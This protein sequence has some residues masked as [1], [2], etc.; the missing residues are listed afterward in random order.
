[1]NAIAPM[2]NGV[3]KDEVERNANPVWILFRIVVP[4]TVPIASAVD[5]AVIAFGFF[6]QSNGRIRNTLYIL[7]G[8]LVWIILNR[9]Y[10]LVLHQ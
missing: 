4:A 8:L 1:M 7:R 6:L 2:I 9:V 5:V 3:I 10:N